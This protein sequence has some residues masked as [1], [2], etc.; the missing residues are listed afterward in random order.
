[1]VSSDE[2]DSISTRKLKSYI[3]KANAEEMP[4][5]DKWTVDEFECEENHSSTYG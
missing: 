3:A 4:P 5:M 2:K 1:M